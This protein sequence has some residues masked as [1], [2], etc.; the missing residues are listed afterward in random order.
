MLEECP[1]LITLPIFAQYLFSILGRCPFELNEMTSH[2]N[3]TPLL[4]HVVSACNMPFSWTQA[5]VLGGHLSFWFVVG[6]FRPERRIFTSADCGCPTE[7]KFGQRDIIP[8]IR[9][10]I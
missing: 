4:L 2:S 6:L 1:S 9:S 7:T 3:V 10:L 5:V 8:T